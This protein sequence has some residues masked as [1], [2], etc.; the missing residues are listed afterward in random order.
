MSKLPTRISH[1]WYKICMR[2]DGILSLVCFLKFSANLKYALY[3]ALKSCKN[4]KLQKNAQSCTNIIL[5]V[6]YRIWKLWYY[7]LYSK[8]IWVPWWYPYYYEILLIHLHCSI[9]NISMERT[10]VTSQLNM[11]PKWYPKTFFRKIHIL[12]FLTTCQSSV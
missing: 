6:W 9:D 7:N 3:Y 2:S 1:F 12:S 5:E 10:N 11:V 4:I 8:N